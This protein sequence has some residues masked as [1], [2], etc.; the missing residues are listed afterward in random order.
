MAP[1]VSRLVL[2]NLGET[3]TIE[4]SKRTRHFS[5]VVPPPSLPPSLI[6]SAEYCECREVVRSPMVEAQCSVQL[7][8]PVELKNVSMVC[9][10]PFG[11]SIRCSYW[12]ELINLSIWKAA[13]LHP[14]H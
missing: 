7:A 1:Y 9:F 14:L 3:S 6:S 8:F 11:M 12:N 13:C 4:L 2:L 10:N 5:S